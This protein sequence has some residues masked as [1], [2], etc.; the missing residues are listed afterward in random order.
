MSRQRGTGI[1]SAN[2]N[3]FLFLKAFTIP[4]PSS[5]AYKKNIYT[6]VLRALQGVS[7]GAG[8]TGVPSQAYSGKGLASEEVGSC[9]VDGT[10]IFSRDQD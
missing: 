8:I 6:S 10:N 7:E 3:F 5:R 1:A 9:E 4:P 2:I